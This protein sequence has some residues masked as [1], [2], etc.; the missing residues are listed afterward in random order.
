MRN[1]VNLLATFMAAQPRQVTVISSSVEQ[2]MKAQLPT[3]D[4]QRQQMV[5]DRMVDRWTFWSKLQGP[6][7]IQFPLRDDRQLRSFMGIRRQCLE[8]ADTIAVASGGRPLTWLSPG[9]PV[10][11]ARPE[12]A[13]T[14]PGCTR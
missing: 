3:H 7:P 9:V 5:V 1:A 6:R 10:Y 13:S 11:A 4:P 8:W 2:R 14:T 12:W